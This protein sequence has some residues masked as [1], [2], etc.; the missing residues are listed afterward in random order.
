MSIETRTAGE[1]GTVHLA[2][3]VPSTLPDTD[4]TALYDGQ[5]RAYLVELHKIGDVDDVGRV[6]RHHYRA[7][8]A[9]ITGQRAVTV[10]VEQAESLPA[11]VPIHKKSGT[12]VPQDARDRF[13]DRIR[14]LHIE[15]GDSR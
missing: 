10:R 9:T 5:E 3:R 8:Y 13:E 11:A 4:R 1:R 12:L 6:W 15:D 7:V 2:A 14:S